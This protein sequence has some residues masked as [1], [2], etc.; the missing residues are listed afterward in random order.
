MNEKFDNIITKFKQYSKDDI[1]ECNF[2]NT[3]VDWDCL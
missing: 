1:K 3:L 2:E